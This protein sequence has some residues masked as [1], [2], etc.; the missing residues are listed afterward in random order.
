MLRRGGS[1]PSGA[2]LQPPTAVIEASGS[3][4]LCRRYPGMRGEPFRASRPTLG[5]VGRRAVE[6]TF[7]ARPH[8]PLRHSNPGRQATSEQ[9]RVRGEA[10]GGGQV[11]VGCRV[12]VHVRVGGGGSSGTAPERTAPS[13][14]AESRGRDPLWVEHGLHR[15]SC[16]APGPPRAPVVRA[17]HSHHHASQLR[18]HAA[19]L[20]LCTG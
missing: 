7:I 9:N 2:R 19:L 20:P 13:R 15:V 11:D 17:P 4:P 10:A 6:N 3:D 1:H 5:A 12:C 8:L 16:S 14:R 18:S